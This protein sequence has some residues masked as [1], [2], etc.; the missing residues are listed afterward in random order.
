MRRRIILTD[1]SFT[2]KGV[3]KLERAAAV[4]FVTASSGIGTTFND[5]SL[6][7]HVSALFTQI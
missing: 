6:S 7:T 5:T 3:I 2:A 4:R 1:G